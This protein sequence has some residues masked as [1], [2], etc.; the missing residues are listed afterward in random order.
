MLSRTLLAAAL[1]LVL[2]TGH[3]ASAAPGHGDAPHDSHERQPERR[4][5]DDRRSERDGHR[6]RDRGPHKGDSHDRRHCKSDDHH[7]V[8]FRKDHRQAWKLEATFHHSKEANRAVRRLEREHF[9]ARIVSTD[10]SHHA[11]AC[12]ACHA[13][14]HAD[15][16]H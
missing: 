10:H 11:S 1:G 8:W 9:E 14:S 15:A 16:R 6:E 4:H 5:E 13:D 7:E 12:R 3:S 2:G